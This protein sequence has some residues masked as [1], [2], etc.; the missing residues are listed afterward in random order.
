MKKHR[1]P[2]SIYIGI[3]L[4][5]LL[6]G[7]FRDCKAQTITTPINLQYAKAELNWSEQ[8]YNDYLKHKDDKPINAIENPK[9]FNHVTKIITKNPIVIPPKPRVSFSIFPL[10][11]WALI[12]EE[13]H[14]NK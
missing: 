12:K 11:P 14:E 9:A 1:H 7:L 10:I 5:F 6:S 3:F 2:H 13:Y 4:L 8:E